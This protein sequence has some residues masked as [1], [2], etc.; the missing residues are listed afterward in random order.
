MDPTTGALSLLL[1]NLKEHPR[2]MS[3]SDLAAAVGINRNTVSRYLDVLLVS[4]QV[5]METYGKAK[6]FY[7]SQRVPIAAMLEDPFNEL[8][9]PDGAELK[10]K[11]LASLVKVRIAQAY[12][13]HG[14]WEKALATYHEVWRNT[15]KG[16]T[17]HHYTQVEAIRGIVERTRVLYRDSRYDQIYEIYTRYRGSFIKELQ[18]S[19]TLF[20]IGDALNRLGQTEEARTMLELSTRGDSIYKEQAFSLLFTIDIKRNKFQEALIWN[21]IYLSTYPDGKDARI[22]RERRGEVL[23]RL[24]RS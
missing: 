1:S 2:G 9:P 18:D 22:M 7:L 3:V 4:G 23:Y 11:A 17:I 21:T 13:K 15:K 5:E 20:I 10:D 16:D 24:R 8:D 6:V 12:A 14:D 19:A